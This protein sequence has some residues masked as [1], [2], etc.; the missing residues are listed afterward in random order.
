MAQGWRAGALRPMSGVA[1]GKSAA[2]TRREQACTWS[3][4]FLVQ[5]LSIVLLYLGAFGLVAGV[6]SWLLRMPS[7]DLGS[8]WLRAVPVGLF[9]P[10]YLRNQA[11]LAVH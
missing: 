11:G 4:E 3:S 2:T 7:T 10:C 1:A 9:V 8:I 5:R 6:F